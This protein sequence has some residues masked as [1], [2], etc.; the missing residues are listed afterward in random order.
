MLSLSEA[1]AQVTPVVSQDPAEL[2][3]PH[4][5]SA[6]GSP[7][8]VPDSLSLCHHNRRQILRTVNY[9]LVALHLFSSSSIPATLRCFH[10]V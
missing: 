10:I 3:L 8:K 2:E 1:D 4:P 6:G 7:G 5:S 9:C